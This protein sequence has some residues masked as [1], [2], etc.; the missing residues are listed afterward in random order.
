MADNKELQY[1]K[2]W[3]INA[4]GDKYEFTNQNS[5]IFLNN[6]A[7]FGFQR[8][9][10]SIMVGNSEL[11]T[12]QQF[13]MTDITGELLFYNSPNGEIYE[14]YFDFI[15]FA[16]L[17]PL[18]FHYQTPNILGS[19]YCDVLFIQASKGE[20]SKDDGILHVPVTFHRLTQWLDATDYT[21][22]LTNTIYENGKEYPLVREYHYAGTGLGNTPIYNKGTDDIG[23][24]LQINGNVQNPQFS[25][26]Q[27]GER[28]GI[29]KINGTYD[30][31]MIDSVEKTES[32]YL[33]RN[34]SALTNPEQYQDF[35]IRDGMAYLT[36]LKLKVGESTF[37]FT[38]G[39]IDTFDGTVTIS[40]KNSY[41]TV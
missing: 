37:S 1:R 12:S 23:F 32:I 20:V 29:C 8:M 33:E 6:P 15:Q 34:G 7:G 5:K 38:C 31:I 14:D 2:H 9:Y 21:I 26:S 24:I 10:S 28:Y 30:Y 19:Y 16:K 41:V 11:V 39:N 22:E 36:W 40:F 25:L 17:K 27:Y 4:V 18:E 35:T 3:L 13:Q